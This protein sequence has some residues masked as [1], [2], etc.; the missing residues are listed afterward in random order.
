[1]FGIGVDPPKPVPGEEAAVKLPEPVPQAR[2]PDAP[3]LVELIRTTVIAL[4]QAN[5]V[6]DYEVL[7]G[8]SAPGFQQA[9]SATQLAGHFEGLKARD[10]DLAPVSVIDPKLFRP[11]AI[12]QQGFL[13]LTGFFPSK[14]E[15]VN[16]DLAFQFVEG[17]WRLFGIGLNTTREQ[18]AA[19]TDTPQGASPPV[20]EPAAAPP[21]S[22][23]PR[24]G[25]PPT[26]RVRPPS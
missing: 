26:P 19:P 6:G 17:Q 11:P 1:L 8:I 15:Q 24:I 18:I 5:Q 20:A 23:V 22:A 10:L 3:T 2:I 13:R 16:F 7:R 9:N 21:A 4:N 14:P 12:D 25:K